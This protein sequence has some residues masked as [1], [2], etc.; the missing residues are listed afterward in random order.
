MVSTSFRILAVAMTLAAGAAYGSDDDS[1]SRHESDA[2]AAGAGA[3]RG[4]FQTVPNAA[5]AGEPGFGWQFFAN[6]AGRRAVVISPQ[7]AYYFSRGKGLRPVAGTGVDR[8]TGAVAPGS[9][10]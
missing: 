4:A 10:G 6:A 1:R 5:A 2:R 9:R 8:S 7:G 3:T